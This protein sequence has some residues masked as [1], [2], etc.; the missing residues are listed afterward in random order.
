MAHTKSMA[1]TTS[2]QDPI[3]PVFDPICASDPDTRQLT[4]SYGVRCFRDD[5]GLTPAP[6][7]RL[8]GRWLKRAG[9]A[10]GDAV[11]VRVAGGAARHREGGGRASA[12]LRGSGEAGG[13]RQRGRH[14]EAEIR[15][16]RTAPQTILYGLMPGSA[17][18]PAGGRRVGATACGHSP[19]VARWLGEAE[20]SHQPWWSKR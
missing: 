13:S 11:K 12:A 4:V 2:A 17:T 20:W 14:P 18:G 6:L 3:C 8:Q 9:F 5:D 7:L 10:V 19:N 16:D 1:S 15:G